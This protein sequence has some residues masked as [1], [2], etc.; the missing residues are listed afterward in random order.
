MSYPGVIAETIAFTGHNGDAGEAY[1]A[2][3][4]GPGPYPGVVLIHHMPG[5][6]EWMMEQTRKLAHHG[7]ATICPHLYFREGPG[8]P[9]DVG[10]RVRA[11]GGVPDAQVMGDAA[12]ALKFLRAQNW[13]NGKVAVM[14]YCSGGRHAYL[15][16][17]TVPGFD[18]VVDCWGGNVIVD[19]PKQLNEKRPVAPIDLTEKLKVPLLGLFGND[20]ANPTADQVNRTEAVLKKLGKDYEFHRYDGVG[21]AFFNYERPGFKPEPM[22][23]GWKKVFAFLDRNLAAKLAAAE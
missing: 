18:A 20:D 14:G 9:D 3:P 16:G 23:E 15:A 13:S 11:A 7:F 6:D 4:Q 21:H 22:L 19:D 1:L 10:A 2:R 5:W 8:S 12:A 17:C